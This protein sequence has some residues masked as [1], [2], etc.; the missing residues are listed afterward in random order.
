MAKMALKAHKA[1]RGRKGQQ[2]CVEVMAN[3]A[4]TVY[5]V[6]KGIRRCWPKKVQ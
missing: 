2:A 5:K 3:P 4:A 6:R 1:R